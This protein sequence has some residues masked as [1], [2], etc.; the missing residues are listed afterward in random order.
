MIDTLIKCMKE[1]V[2]DYEETDRSKWVMKHPGQ[3]VA[4]VAQIKW[5]YMTEEHLIEM[6]TN[7]GALKEWLNQNEE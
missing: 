4:T 5:S 1:G 7:R 2:K 3:V 6:S